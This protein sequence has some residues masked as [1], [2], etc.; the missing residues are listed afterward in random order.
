MNT[1]RKAN[2]VLLYLRRNGY[3]V[4][5][6]TIRIILAMANSNEEDRLKVNLWLNGY[7]GFY[8]EPLIN[9]IKFLWKGIERFSFNKQF[10]SLNKLLAVMP[11][12]L[13]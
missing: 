13:K 4:T 5:E 2:V 10:E 12:E 1:V 6:D 9:R 3:S 8:I 11:K 7:G